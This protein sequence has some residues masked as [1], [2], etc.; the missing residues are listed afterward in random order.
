[1]AN[2]PHSATKD[3][4]A[5]HS[6]LLNPIMGR[7]ATEEDPC[8]G[9]EAWMVNKEPGSPG[10]PGSLVECRRSGKLSTPYA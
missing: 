3:T 6:H 4:M 1:M 9:K 5:F 8:V 10:S 2:P 7:S